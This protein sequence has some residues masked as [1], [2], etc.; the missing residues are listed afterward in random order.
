ML[1][2]IGLDPLGYVAVQRDRLGF[3][4]RALDANFRLAARLPHVACTTRL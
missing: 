1:R 4:L 2:R 3:G